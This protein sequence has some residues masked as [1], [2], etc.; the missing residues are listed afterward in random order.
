MCVNQ[1]NHSLYLCTSLASCHPAAPL[2]R[3]LVP[4]L[5]VEALPRF[6]ST[7]GAPLLTSPGPPLPPRSARGAHL[8]AQQ[9]VCQH[10]RRVVNVKTFSSSVHPP[11]TD[12]RGQLLL[13][14]RTP[15]LWGSPRR[16]GGK[17]STVAGSVGQMAPPSRI[18]AALWPSP[19][20][21]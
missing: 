17:G 14:P 6:G 1:E 18:I 2:R 21:R 19:G 5:T 13:L 8:Y 3:R 16:G 4:R 12:T 15:Q 7:F 20:A 10:L 9:A 11:L